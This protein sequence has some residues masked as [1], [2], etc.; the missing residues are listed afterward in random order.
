MHPPLSLIFFFLTAGTSVGLFTIL[1]T[2]QIL[3]LLG[4]GKAL[5]EAVML[6]AGGVCLLLVV[7]GALTASL[8]L[9]HRLRAWKAVRRFKTSWL[10]REAVFSGAYGVMLLLYLITLL[11]GYGVTGQL[12]WGGLAFIT[13]VL[14]AYSTAM[15]YATNRF[16]LEWNSSITVAGFLLLYLMLGST[17]GTF[18]LKLHG[19]HTAEVLTFLS[20]ALLILGFLLRIAFNIRQ[21]YIRRPT[22]NDALNLPRNRPVRLLDA[23]TTTENYC[24]TEFYYRKGKEL[25]PTVIPLAYLLNFL[26][27]FFLIL[28]P[29]FSGSGENWTLGLSYVSLFV[30]AALERW[31]FFV[32]GNHVQN[33]FYGLYPSER[34][35]RWRRG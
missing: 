29:R 10:S 3:N 21:F 16:V 33:L 8:H 30:G 7:A 14:S 31:C 11:Q 26:I 13:G 15:I 28:Y 34:E 27:P 25:L 24:T 1:F 9:G 17:A 2:L 20:L 19:L 22:L 35:P 6:K 32:E 5:P 23:G 12:I 4:F 18:L